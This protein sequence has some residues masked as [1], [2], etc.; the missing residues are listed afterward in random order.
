M[1]RLVQRATFTASLGISFLLFQNTNLIATP[2]K[3]GI[4]QQVFSQDYLLY[5][6]PKIDPD[7]TYWLVCYAH[8][9]RGH[10]PEDL[11]IINYFSEQEDCIVIAPTFSRGYQLLEHNSDQRVI[12][13]FQELKKKYQL[14]DKFFILGHSAGGQFAHRFTLKHPDLIV[15]C[16]ACSSG[17]WATGGIYHS[18]NQKAENIP[19]AIGCGMEDKGK[20]GLNMALLSLP[21]KTVEKAME[22]AIAWTRIEWFTI[23]EE[24]LYEKNFFYKSIIFVGQSHRIPTDQQIELA[25]EAFFLG[26]SGMLPDERASYEPDI[27]A[28]NAAIDD[29]KFE[30]AEQGIN[31]LISKS[32]CRSTVELKNSLI[33]SHWQFSEK[34]LSEC[35]QAFKTFINEETLLLK[36]RI[37]N[38]NQFKLNLN[39]LRSSVEAPAQDN[40]SLPQ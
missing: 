14:H 6:P 31:Q 34:E 7:K 12:E 8:G 36:K 25:R 28:I 23:F 16:E 5:L 39:S 3:G 33:S 22:E 18:L 29:S 13:I 15:G 26:T 2:A 35:S 10:L 27:S 30:E 1:K 19:I 21:Y 17:T 38:K 4:Q 20:I 40:S 32:H 11:P 9:A 37:E 24:L